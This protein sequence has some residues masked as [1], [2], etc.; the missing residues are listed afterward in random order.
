MFQR[1]RHIRQN[2]VLNMVFPGAE[3][4][5]SRMPWESHGS[6]AES[7]KLP[8]GT[9]RN[10]R[11]VRVSTGMENR[12]WPHCSMTS[13]TGP[14]HIRWKDILKSLSVD[15]NH[16][17]MTTRIFKEEGSEIATILW[18]S[19]SAARPVHRKEDARPQSL[20]LC[21][22]VSALD[23]NRLDYLLRDSTM[24]GVW[25]NRFNLG[26]LVD[27]L[28]IKDDELVVDARARDVVESYLLSMEKMYASVYYHH[29]NRAASFLLRGVVS[30]AVD[31]A[32][33]S[34][35]KERSCFRRRMAN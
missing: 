19:G 33:R 30:R 1:L 24:A 12:F 34:K 25:T 23:A 27:A 18:G 35:R 29:T 16:E 14:S 9:R 15:F 20:V 11:S 28:G 4:S 7:S 26:R 13:D 17:K 2:G 22:R 3:H 5:G 21:H 8:I 31:V 10:P 6:R 32:R